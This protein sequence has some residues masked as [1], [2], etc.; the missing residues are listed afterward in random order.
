MST[1][2]ESGPR[3]ALLTEDDD[4]FA[5]VQQPAVEPDDPS[6]ESELEWQ[7]QDPA[8][9]DLGR[10][11]GAIVLAVVAAVFLVFAGI[12][13]GRETKSSSTKVVTV[14]AAS[15]AEETPVA[16]GAA[17]NSAATSTPSTSESTPNAGTTT[18]DTSTSTPSTST[19]STDTSTS[20]TS[21]DTSTPSSNAVPTDATLRRGAKGASVVA[22][23]NALTTLGYPPGTPDGSYG[24][25]TAEAVA[26][27]QAAKSLT[28]DGA[29]GPKTLAAINAALASG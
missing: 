23:Q 4:W 21:T 5:T 25:T 3:G 29:A 11:Q 10:R 20:T 1:R 2:L 9:P 6:W 16:T 17:D 22:L 18:P 12:L 27:F 24:A 28:A 14:T 7:F 8:P 15:Q 26:A 19:P 13:I